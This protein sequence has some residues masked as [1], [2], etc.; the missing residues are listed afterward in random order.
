MRNAALIRAQW[1]DLRDK[2]RRLSAHECALLRMRW[3]DIELRHPPAA[4]GGGWWQPS[5]LQARTAGTSRWRD[6]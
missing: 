2:Y 4:G 5:L 3:P 1:R 6:L